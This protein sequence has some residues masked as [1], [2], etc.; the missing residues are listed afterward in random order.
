MKS[1]DQKAE[2]IELRAK[3]LS[4]AKVCEQLHISKSTCSSWEQELKAQIEE[5]KEARIAE[6]Y[7]LYAMDR[8][9]RIQRI[10]TV[11]DRINTALEEKDLS[12]LP[13]DTLLKLKLKYEQELR[14]EYTEPD[15]LPF[16][17]E[18]TVEEAIKAL[19]SL[20]K[21]QENGTISPAQAKAQLATITTLLSA[22]KL[23]SANDVW[24]L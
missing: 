21:K 23:K 13:A 9:S 6:L 14:A 17:E 4:Y 16:T 15:S 7:T 22:G 5:L 24:E 11:L 1:T 10:G 19:S 18:A 2:F 20:Y 8:A 12:E 3:G